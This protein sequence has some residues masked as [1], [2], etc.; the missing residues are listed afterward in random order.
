M[1]DLSEYLEVKRLTVA[2]WKASFLAKLAKTSEKWGAVVKMGYDEY[3]GSGNRFSHLLIVIMDIS[4]SEAHPHS[5]SKPNN[6]A[7]FDFDKLFVSIPQYV[8][9]IQRI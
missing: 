8:Q 7:G 4:I 3:L 6:K 2:F 9:H 5:A 1:W